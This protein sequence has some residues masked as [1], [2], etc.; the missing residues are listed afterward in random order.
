LPN[1]LSQASQRLS[2]LTH[3]FDDLRLRMMLI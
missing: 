3:S 2:G 1:S